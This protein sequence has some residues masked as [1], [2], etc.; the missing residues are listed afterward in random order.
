[1][2]IVQKLLLV[3]TI[4]ICCQF[5]SEANK[6]HFSINS[7][8]D[9]I[10]DPIIEYKGNRI[11]VKSIKVLKKKGK[12]Y[13]IEY[14]LVNTGRNKIKLG[15]SINIPKDLIFQFDNS[16][17][18]NDLGDAKI[19]IIE[20]IKKQ[21]ISIR[22]GQLMMGNKLKFSYK[23]IPPSD[24]IAANDSLQKKEE[25][26]L[27]KPKESPQKNS[28]DFDH[29]VK[30]IV[31]EVPLNNDELESPR[32]PSSI[33]NDSF[34]LDETILV[35][36]PN[37]SITQNTAT[38]PEKL[39]DQK[40]ELVV[41]K[42]EKKCADLVLENVEII[43]NNK[44]FVQVKYTIKNIGNI[45]ISLHGATKKEIDN[46]ALESYFTRSHNLTR[47]S[48]PVDV[49]FIKKGKKDVMG[50][51]VPGES[52]TQKLKVETSKVTRFTPVLALS[53]NPNST[54]F[55]CDRINNVIFI[56]IAEKAP[57]FNNPN[58]NKSKDAKENIEKIT[59]LDQK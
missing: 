47:G 21:N 38:S 45:P 49:T 44:R 32:N 40:A 16:L 56:D 27:E 54:I 29:A 7:L 5:Q 10:P 9:T 22:P 57:E 1:M 43:K 52:I 14:K 24:H 34:K 26:T 19:S 13:K 17:L 4:L 35:N 48:I 15:K 55:E 28:V 3:F 6:N 20:N 33:E 50:N 23:P 59:N 37:D 51:L 8:L 58:I 18:E 42:N 39:E 2:N 36:N 30:K 25:E 53:L 31:E 12:N 11:M 41:E 46:I